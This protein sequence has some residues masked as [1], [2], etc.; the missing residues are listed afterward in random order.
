MGMHIWIKEEV[1]DLN[2]QLFFYDSNCCPLPFCSGGETKRSSVG[3]MLAKL[4]SSHRLMRRTKGP[5]GWPGWGR[6]QTAEYKANKA[7]D[8]RTKDSSVHRVKMTVFP[9]GRAPNVKLFTNSLS[10]I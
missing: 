8:S 5:F 2:Q 7:Q 4:M 3:A 9:R 10:L 6:L 1:Q